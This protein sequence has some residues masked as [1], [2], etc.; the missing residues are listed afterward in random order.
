MRIPTALLGS[1]LLMAGCR[2]PEVAVPVEYTLDCPRP[3]DAQNLVAF[4]RFDDGST[5]GD[6]S[7]DLQGKMSLFGPKGMLVEDRLGGNGHGALFVGEDAAMG[8]SVPGTLDV[9]GDLTLAAWV[10][11]P[12]DWLAA[13]EGC[14]DQERAL[15]IVSV[16]S[17]EHGQTRLE[18]LHVVGAAPLLRVSVDTEAGER[19]TCAELPS[20]FGHWGRGRWYHV[21]GTT[22][23]SPTL[24][25]DGEPVAQ[26]RCPVAER[27]YASHPVSIGQLVASDGC[28]FGRL[29]DDVALFQ[30]PLTA[31]QFP[32]FLL[33]SRAVFG[34]DGRWW[35]V[36]GV[37]G[38][39]AEWQCGAAYSPDEGGLQA[40]FDNKPWSA[41]RLL[42]D[43][44]P[45]PIQAFRGA[46]LRANV[47]VGEPFELELEGEER[48]HYCVWPALGRGDDEYEFLAEDVGW[49]ECPGQCPCDF[50]VGRAS[51]ESRWD[52]SSRYRV[53]AF[54]IDFDFQSASGSGQAS[55]AKTPPRSLDILDWCWRPVAY[56]PTAHAR[57]GPSS[58]RNTFE[59]HLGAYPSDEVLGT[60]EG[61]SQLTAFL[62][63]DFVG[64]GAFLNIEECNRVHVEADVEPS[65]VRYSLRLVDAY[66]VVSEVKTEGEPE[67]EID[68]KGAQTWSPPQVRELG[69]LDASQVEFTPTMVRF[70]GIQKPWDDEWPE[71]TVRIRDIE[72]MTSD[73]Q[74]CAELTDARLTAPLVIIEEVR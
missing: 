38:S 39:V 22:G 50:M 11:L 71:S 47:P 55:L 21:A 37:E 63:A 7:K 6:W 62:G 51:I 19:E 74:S 25:V 23:T 42:V 57:L 45:A 67:V 18:I 36:Q 4:W 64:M 59:A 40:Y 24:Y 72:F 35:S 13:P 66:G 30:P 27:A 46:V 48:N 16:V 8:S 17:E 54:D 14:E 73:G 2:G 26:V 12:E 9:S 44:D 69:K 68:L 28:D 20:Q 10:S 60:L 56:E 5:G 70:V 58:A 1:S 31:G 33:R 61:A 32:G 43:V 52:T 65:G 3:P 34:P 15:E 53:S 49:C 41:P 29:L